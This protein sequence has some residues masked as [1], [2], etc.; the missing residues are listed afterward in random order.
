MNSK[1]LLVFLFLLVFSGVAGAKA[2]VYQCNSCASC[3][4]YIQNGSLQSGD[5]LRLT[6]DISNQNGTCIEINQSNITFD[7][8]GHT[9]DGD[10]DSNGYGI[11]VNAYDYGALANITIQNCTIQEFGHGV[12]FKGSLSN[13]IRNSE[14]YD[15]NSSYNMHGVSLFRSSSNTLQNITASF[16]DRDGI[17]L[18][19]SSSNTLQNI[20]ASFNSRGMRLFYAYSNK[21]KDF[22]ITS[23]SNYGIYLSF[24]NSN[25]I[26]NTIIQNNSNC[27]L[28]IYSCISNKIYNNLFDNSV[29]FGFWENR[30]ANHWNTALNCSLGPNIIG[31][32]CIGGN[33]WTDPNGGNFSDECTDTNGDGICDAPYTLN[34]HNTDFY[35]LTRDKKPPD[36]VFVSPTP[37][38]G[39][40]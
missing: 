30:D 8:A 38:N 5:V 1:K 7:C 28:Y 17:N 39:T 3:T 26:T 35:P 31:G 37:E 29:N 6:A 27:G 15:I 36:L 14:I 9:I 13:S 16:N 21:I 12:Y 19:S 20:T 22:T 10:G 32:P 40:N 24:S 4:E 2:A 11:Y 18:D 25:T 33:Y 34:A 23:N